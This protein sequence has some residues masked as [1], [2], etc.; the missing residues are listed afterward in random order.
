[1]EAGTLYPSRAN[2]GMLALTPK[3]WHAMLFYATVLPVLF[4]GFIMKKGGQV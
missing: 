2:L 4:M 3:K 1:M